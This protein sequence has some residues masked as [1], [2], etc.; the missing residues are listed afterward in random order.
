ME[1][2][3]QQRFPMI[4]TRGTDF[5]GNFQRGEAE[6]KV[7]PVGSGAERSVSGYVHRGAGDKNIV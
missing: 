7:S 6:E 2:K 1:N 3:L 4:R 5:K